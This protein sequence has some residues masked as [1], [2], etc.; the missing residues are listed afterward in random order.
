MPYSASDVP[1]PSH[2]REN[3][4][5]E[6]PETNDSPGPTADPS[7][8]TAAPPEA[9]PEDPRV[10]ELQNLVVH[11]KADFDNYKKRAQKESASAVRT[12]ELEAVKKFL[13]AFANLERAI[14]AAKNAG[15]TGALVDGVRAIYEQFQSILQSIGVER[16]P[17]LGVPFD[18]SLHDAVAAAARTDVPPGTVTDEFEPGYRADGRALIP[19][20]VRVSTAE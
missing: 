13:P 17:A 8:T 12:G 18:P 20:K 4:P 5:P 2:P 16:V 19:A 10:A 1:G 7:G 6:K 11:L 14:T 3:V 15:E 9:A